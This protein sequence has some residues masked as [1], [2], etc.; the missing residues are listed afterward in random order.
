VK[1][2]FG[3]SSIG[4]EVI[5]DW[6]SVIAYLR[7][8]QP[9]LRAGAV[10]EPFRADAVDLEVA[11][12]RHPALA[13]SPIS[14]PLRDGESSAIYG[15]RDKYVGGEGMASAP[16]ELPA[17]LPSDVEKA[18]REWT[19]RVAELAMVRGVARLDFLMTGGEVFV[20]EINTIP[21]SLAWMLW[22]EPRVPF[23]TLLRDMIDE[24]IAAP[25][26]TYSVV[27]ADGSVLRSSASI[28]AKLG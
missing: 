1:P 16:R 2:R 8:P 14:K 28:S 13:Q 15:Y 26:R 23:L 24:V 20:N 12:R 9:L 25:A 19:A 17:E 22:A 10:V 3:G 11:V 4:I 21:G 5:E 18:I 27:G 6:D 7:T